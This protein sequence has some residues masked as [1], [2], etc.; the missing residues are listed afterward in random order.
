LTTNLA[1]Y[2]DAVIPWEKRLGREMP[3]LEEVA[4]QAGRRI[5]LPACGTGGHIVALAELGFEVLG[6]DVDEDALALARAKIAEARSSIAARG[7]HAEVQLLNMADGGTLGSIYDSAFCLGNALPSMSGSG[8]LLA[9]LRGVAGA[10]RPGGV[11]FTQNLNFDLRWREKTQSF[12]VLSGATER[13]EVLL[14]KFAD[15]DAEFINFH[16]MFLSRPKAGGAWQSQVRNSR[17]VPLFRDRLLGLLSQAGFSDFI[18]WGDY[19]RTA[20]DAQKSHDLLV[21]AQKSS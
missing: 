6:L 11:F 13:E 2:F 3:L 21:Y 4:R 15:Y 10:L 19:A 18:C 16:G 7:G 5:L 17:W 9:A 8:Q 14:V 12:P 1:Q 20:F